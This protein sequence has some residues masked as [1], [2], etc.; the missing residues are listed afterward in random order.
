MRCEAGLGETGVG[1]LAL[2]EELRVL[3]EVQ[4][5]TG[6]RFFCL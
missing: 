4:N 3:G 2:Y 1:V 6:P 5:P